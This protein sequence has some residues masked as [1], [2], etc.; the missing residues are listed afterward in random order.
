[1]DS[2]KLKRA[3]ILVF[4]CIGLYVSTAVFSQENLSPQKIEE[5][6]EKE[7]VEVKPEAVERVMPAYK[8][9]LKQFIE[10]AKRNI[11][12]V[13]EEIR[14]QE[15]LERNRAREVKIREHFEKGNSLYREGRLKEAKVEWEKALD[16]AKDPELRDYIREAAKRA[17]QA[18]L[19]RQEEER[20]VKQEQAR[21]ERERKE[22]EIE[23]ELARQK[24]ELARKKAEQERQRQLELGK[25]E[26]ERSRK[27]KELQE[28]KKL[29]SK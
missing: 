25:K 10:E 12:K 7:I 27:K 14:Q 24:E 6:A 3:L 8:L 18:E 20:K 15:I 11:K 21:L 29:K 22:K 1:M 16:F 28:Q 17:E 23:E 26:A 4:M 9:N 5:K 2:H 13:E 19:T